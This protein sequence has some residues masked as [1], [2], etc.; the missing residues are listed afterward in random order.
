VVSIEDITVSKVPHAFE[1][2]RHPGHK[3]LYTADGERINEGQG[4]PLLSDKLFLR[5]NGKA[6]PPTLLDASSPMAAFSPSHD[7]FPATEEAMQRSWKASR[8]ESFADTTQ[9]V[10]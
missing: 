1:E 8:S 5:T 7:I 3:V 4:H 2:D 10:G 6:M 9:Y